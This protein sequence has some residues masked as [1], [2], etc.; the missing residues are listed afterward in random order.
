MIENMPNNDIY[1][2]KENEAN[3]SRA[4]IEDCK[5]IQ[6]G[7]PEERSAA[8][9]RLIRRNDGMIKEIANKY[10]CLSDGVLEYDDIYQ[11]ASIGLLRAAETYSPEKS[12]F[13]T[14]AHIWMKQCITRDIYDH[15]STVRVPLHAMEEYLRAKRKYPTTSASE[16]FDSVMADNE[17]NENQKVMIINAFN[18]LNLDSLDRS[19]GEDDD[20]GMTIGSVQS[21]GEDVSEEVVATIE[22][23]RLQETV[24]AI[25][26][27]K[28]RWV[29]L[30]RFGFEDG[31]I[32][33]L[34]QCGNNY[35]WGKVSK[36]RIRQI[37]VKA[38][39]RLRARLR[40]RGFEPEDYHTTKVV[41]APASQNKV[42]EMS[43]EA[44]DLTTPAVKNLKS[45]HL[46]LPPVVDR[47][48]SSENA[49]VRSLAEEYRE[50]SRLQ[51]QKED[52]QKTLSGGEKCKC[53][54]AIHAI[55][56]ERNKIIETITAKQ[57]QAG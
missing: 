16:F 19:I 43:S 49:E 15:K 32:W 17:Y 20:D 40:L 25:L 51:L 55:E 8:K 29:I 45:W 38:I 48:L 6:T 28:E 46:T 9:D 31:N 52:L 56:R 36:E 37:E 2:A 11:N 12:A 14:Y 5:I 13:S 23:E 54:R 53:T 35:P 7:T 4:N 27:E 42:R 3:Y 41:Y 24:K 26:P 50:L 1:V 57:S 10:N 18:V 39:R 34:E 47:A 33:T 30:H 21:T 22:N 44:S